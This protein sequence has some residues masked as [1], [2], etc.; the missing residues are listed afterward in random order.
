MTYQ[1]I[2][3]DNCS[4]LDLNSCPKSVGLQKYDS[5]S[6]SGTVLHLT[7][8]EEGGYRDSDILFASLYVVRGCSY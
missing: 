6:V 4:N 1:H 5:I 7:V 8:T 3:D 2:L